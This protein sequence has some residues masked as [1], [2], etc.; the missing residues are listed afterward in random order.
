[1][2]RENESKA[3]ARRWAWVMGAVGAFHRDRGLRQVDSSSFHFRIILEFC[4]HCRII[5]NTPGYYQSE[6]QSLLKIHVLLSCLN[7]EH[8]DG[9]RS[10]PPLRLCP[11]RTTPPPFLLSLPTGAQSALSCVPGSVELISSTLTRSFIC[12]QRYFQNTN[13]TEERGLKENRRLFMKLMSVVTGAI[14][15]LPL[16]DIHYFL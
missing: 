5:G 8:R 2:H 12:W 10:L 14:P 1:M 3:N 9:Q 4:R 11:L 6:L 7:E 16:Q 13:L 15:E